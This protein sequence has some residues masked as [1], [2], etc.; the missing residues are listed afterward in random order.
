[1]NQ[2]TYNS[3]TNIDYSQQQQ[4]DQAYQYGYYQQYPIDYQQAGFIYDP[5]TGYYQQTVPPYSYFLPQQLQAWQNYNYNNQ[6]GQDKWFFLIMIFLI[7]LV[8]E[9]IFLRKI[10]KII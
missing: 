1:M 3:Y 10:R 6:Y 4:Y 2:S 9:Q 5:N 7:F 8:L